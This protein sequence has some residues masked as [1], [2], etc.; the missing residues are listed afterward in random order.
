MFKS[1]YFFLKLKISEQLSFCPEPVTLKFRLE[2]ACRGVAG[3]DLLIS[4][5]IRKPAVQPQR[6]LED[7]SGQRRRGRLKQ[8]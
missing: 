3:K 2:L 6:H 5:K 1:S 4:F 8:N 7:G